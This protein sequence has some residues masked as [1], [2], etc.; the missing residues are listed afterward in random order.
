MCAPARFKDGIVGVVQVMNSTGQPFCDDDLEPLQNIARLIGYILY[1]ARLL[2]DLATLK[3]LEQEKATFIRIMVHEL[4]SPVNAAKSLVTLF[5]LHPLENPK[6]AHLPGRIST[7]M[8]QLITL[9]KDLLE[10]AKVKSGDPLGNIAVLD[11][12]SETRKGCEPYLAQ[13]EQK[14][15]E[16]HTEYPATPVQV[17]FDSQGYALVLSNLVSNAVKYTPEGVVRLTLKQQNTWAVLQVADSGIGIP[18]A[19]I[20]QLFKEFFRAS[21]AKRQNIQGTGV[22]LAGVKHIVER[23]GGELELQSRENEGSVF[24]VRLPLYSE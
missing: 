22:G 7:R 17:R 13:A 23:F 2:D 10:L 11:L 21:N 16:M 5:D 24:T 14:G 1:N 6:I 19:D 3:R 8:D 4:K 12:V 9:I 18:Q 20:S 15:L